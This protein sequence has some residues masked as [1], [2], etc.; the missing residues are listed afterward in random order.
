MKPIFY[1]VI[2][3]L[4]CGLTACST[5][6]ITVDTESDEGE[7]NSEEI[8]D[9]DSDFFTSYRTRLSDSYTYRDNEI[10]EGFT[11]IRNEQETERNLYEGYRVQ[12]YSGEDV[13][14]AD[15]AA[16][17][18]R[19][20]ADTNINSY[21]PDAYVFFKAPH[22]RVHVG[23]FH[24]R[25]KAIQFSNIVKRQFRDAWVVYD[26]VDPDKVPADT[27]SIDAK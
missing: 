23:D 13:N 24:N 26:R 19:A 17:N 8:I 3:L 14:K 6:E 2:L 7:T 1:I 5:S 25:I 16:A 10:P 21:Q 15:S 9:T 20:W 22:Y 12:I 4:A 27:T 11:R 18:F